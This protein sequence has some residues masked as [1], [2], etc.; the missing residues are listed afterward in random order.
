MIRG[1][2]ST[3]CKTNLERNSFKQ[4]LY[5]CFP[6]AFFAGASGCVLQISMSV[7]EICEFSTFSRLT[8]SLR[9]CPNCLF[10][11]NSLTDAAYR[12]AS[13]LP[14]SDFLP[15][16][17][18][19]RSAKGHQWRVRLQ[20]G[21]DLSVVKSRVKPC[22]LSLLA[23][24]SGAGQAGVLADGRLACGFLE[25]CVGDDVC[26]LVF[27]YVSLLFSSSRGTQMLW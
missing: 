18:G 23:A 2:P 21:G 24:G 13:P 27:I 19:G 22:L 3:C 4:R 9:F 15:A 14:V 6:E 20:R 7:K 11:T 10:L 17:M 25:A 16:W 5:C 12:N 26:V 8:A 1:T